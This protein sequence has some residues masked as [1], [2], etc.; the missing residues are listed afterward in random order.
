MTASRHSHEFE[1]PSR[2]VSAIVARVVLAL[3]L[4]PLW[5]AASIYPHDISGSPIAASTPQAASG[6]PEVVMNVTRRD[7]GDVF[8]GEELDFP[9]DILNAGKAPL[10]L[11]PRRLNSRSRSFG[12]GSLSR[13]QPDIQAERYRLV[14]VAT[15]LAAP[16]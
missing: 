12:F 3:A 13:G 5:P 14:P 1:H 2:C 4:L 6:I 8:A 15:R 7:Y 11:M 9:F 16:T 10:E